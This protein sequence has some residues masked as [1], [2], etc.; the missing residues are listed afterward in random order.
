MESQNL[1]KVIVFTPDR[2]GH[3]GGVWKEF[4]LKTSQRTGTLDKNGTRIK[5]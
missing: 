4:D 2:D 3:N 5:G 1:R